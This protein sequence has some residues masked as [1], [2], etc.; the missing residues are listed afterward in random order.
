M[1]QRPDDHLAF[2]VLYPGT[3]FNGFQFQENSRSVQEEVERVLA[4]LLRQKVRIL[5]TSRTDTGVHALDQ[6][7]IIRNGFHFYEKF[8][9]K[10]RQKFLYSFNSMAHSGVRAWQMLRLS[11]AYHPKTDVKKKSYE[12]RII[13]GSVELP[14][15]SNAWWV[16]RPLDLKIIQKGLKQLL[17][18]H[19]FKGFAHLPEKK[20]PQKFSTV[21]TILNARLKVVRHPLIP[22]SQELIFTFEADG[23]LH[24]MVRI[25]VGTLIDQAIGKKISISDVFT[26][27]D[28]RKA[29]ST[30]PAKGLTLVKTHISS[31]LYKVL[32]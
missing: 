22:H 5:Y 14:H 29:G 2:R 30:A 9:E 17:G 20:L 31:R 16:A 23:F 13:S 1:K 26:S 3:E 32:H 4:I 6:W 11:S 27:R 7:I 15:L 24:N 8:S 18:K 28:R 19:D 25:L 10:D 21:R 12:Y